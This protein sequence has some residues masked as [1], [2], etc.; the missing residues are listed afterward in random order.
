M[1][2][3]KAA[4]VYKQTLTFAGNQQQQS[5]KK[6]LFPETKP[7]FGKPAGSIFFCAS[8]ERLILKYVIIW[9]KPPHYYD[10]DC[11]VFHV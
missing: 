6:V 1:A 8:T 10:D 4:A 2:R 3:K 5:T 9:G 11:L 7:S